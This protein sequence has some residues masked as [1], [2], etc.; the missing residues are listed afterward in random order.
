M[1]ITR[2][3]SAE[4]GSIVENDEFEPEIRDWSHYVSFR[5]HLYFRPH[6]LD[7]LK[8]FMA[9]VRLGIFKQKSIR[10]SMSAICQERSN[11]ILPILLS[12]LLPTGIST[13]FYWL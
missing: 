9:G 8:R 11:S 1:E 3:V 2:P 6:D 10:L 13:T 12:Q 5:P 4:A 7:D